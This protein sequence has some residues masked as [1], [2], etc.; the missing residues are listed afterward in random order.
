MSRSIRKQV[1]H[2]VIDPLGD[3]KLLTGR[4]DRDLIKKK[5]KFSLLDNWLFVCHFL[6]SKKNV[7]SIFLNCNGNITS[8]I[9]E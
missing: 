9:I 2:R 4:A 1:D 8:I 3:T 7:T 5:R 6:P